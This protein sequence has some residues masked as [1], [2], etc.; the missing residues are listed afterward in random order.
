MRGEA[1]A[2]DHQLDR[3][4]VLAREHRR[5]ERALD[6]LSRIRD[7]GIALPFN[8]DASMKA[9]SDTDDEVPFWSLVS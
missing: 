4:A 2:L 3:Y 7:H 5:I 9:E 8:L 6:V 1:G